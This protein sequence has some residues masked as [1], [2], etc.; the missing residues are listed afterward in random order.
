MAH[1]QRTDQP[2][3]ALIANVAVREVDRRDAAPLLHARQHARN[4]FTV[5]TKNSEN[6]RKAK[7]HWQPG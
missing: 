5:F 4:R 1:Q 7:V 2:L 3:D 6:T